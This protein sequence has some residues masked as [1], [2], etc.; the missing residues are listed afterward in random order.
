MRFFTFGGVQAKTK[1][2]KKT[3]EIKPN[4]QLLEQRYIKTIIPSQFSERDCDN[5][6]FYLF[7]HIER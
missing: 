3:K 6:A 2:E 7:F 1:K 5:Q 4:D